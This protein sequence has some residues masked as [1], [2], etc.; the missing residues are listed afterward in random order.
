MARVIIIHSWGSNHEANW[1]PWIKVQL[2]RNGHE[3]IVPDM[4]DT[5]KPVIEKWVEEIKKTVGTPNKDTYF[6]GHSIGCQ[7]I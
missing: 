2:E 6:I 1:Y 5:N 3:V 4:P 7:A